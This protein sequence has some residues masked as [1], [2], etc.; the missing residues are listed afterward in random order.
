M[1]LQSIETV[2]ELYVTNLGYEASGNVAAAKAFLT[3]A[4]EL[5]VRRPKSVTI[6]GTSSRSRV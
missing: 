4:L 6:G 1:P 5:Q 2:T 3:A